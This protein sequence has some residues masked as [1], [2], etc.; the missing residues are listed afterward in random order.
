M[1]SRSFSLTPKEIAALRSIRP[2]G[3][4]SKEMAASLHVSAPGLSRLT[5]SLE[6]RG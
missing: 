5:R 3:I 6:P 1:I 2:G 4:S